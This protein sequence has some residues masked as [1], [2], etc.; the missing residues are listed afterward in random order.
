MSIEVG[1]MSGE[2]ED[3]LIDLNK[4]PPVERKRKMS[5]KSNPDHKVAD[6][7]PKNGWV[8][9]SRTVAMSD[10]EK[11]VIK[12]EIVKME[13]KE[14]TQVPEM[15]CVD[16]RKVTVVK[17]NGK[18]T[19]RRGRPS[20][21]EGRD[22]V[23]S[24]SKQKKRLGTGRFPKEKGVKGALP[25]DNPEMARRG[26]PPKV[27]SECL[28][29]SFDK[30][31]L[32]QEKV[33]NSNTGNGKGR[34]RGRPSGAQ[35][36]KRS[37]KVENEDVGLEVKKKIVKRGRDHKEPGVRIQSKRIKIG[38][39]N[40][41]NGFVQQKKKKVTK[42]GDEGKETGLRY[43]KQLIRDQIVA[44]LQKAGWSVEYR[45]RLTRD[46]HDA[47]YVDRDGRTHWSVTKAYK[48]LEEKIDKGTADDTD[49]LAF[50]PIPEETLR[51]L[52]RMTEPGKKKGNKKMMN[53]TGRTINRAC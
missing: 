52:F 37:L 26:R 31:H 43:Q 32:Q 19:G 51:I 18:K 46:Y 24:L 21:T 40:M 34:G 1:E 9:R 50:T 10:G 33:G 6:G 8:L 39:S 13:D 22:E 20:K 42:E 28:G 16:K 11:Q 3:E 4:E 29:S 27:E 17:K 23:S 47:V 2:G 49:V 48:K 38:M 41:G 45:Q 36:G 15:A 7:L 44:M 14:R 12:M 35:K 5:D 30:K 53:A 25:S